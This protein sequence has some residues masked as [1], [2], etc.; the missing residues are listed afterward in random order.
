MLG[1]GAD[2]VR[3]AGPREATDK[4]E[5]CVISARVPR[6]LAYFEGHF[7]GQ[8]IVPGVAE[9]IGL[10]LEPAREVWP[11][12]PAPEGIKRLKFLAAIGPGDELE[13]ELAREPSRLRFEI[14]R[15][16]TACAQGSFV[17]G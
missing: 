10:V 3:C 5:R 8:P 6:E 2:F 15:G 1:G 14:R 4:G 16:P 17:W 9:L 12:L 7:P 11:D 13:I